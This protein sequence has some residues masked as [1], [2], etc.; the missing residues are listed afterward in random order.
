MDDLEHSVVIAERDWESFY[1]ESE[2]CSIQQAWLASLDDS[3]F[4]DTD[5]EKNSTQGSVLDLQTNPD[6]PNKEPEAAALTQ[7][8]TDDHNAENTSEEPECLSYKTDNERSIEQTAEISLYDVST[9]CACLTSDS[10]V[11]D[12]NFNDQQ[13]IASDIKDFREHNESCS[14]HKSCQAIGEPITSFPCIQDARHFGSS[15]EETVLKVSES[16]ATPKKEKERW[17]VTVNDSPVMLRVKSGQKKGRK[18]KTSR[19]LFQQI[20]VTERQC[21]ISNNKKEE[22]GEVT[23]NEQILQNE[24][25]QPVQTCSESIYFSPC[26]NHFCEEVILS[27]CNDHEVVLSPMK[28]PEKEA[29]EKHSIPKINCTS[30][31]SSFIAEEENIHCGFSFKCKDNSD[32]PTETLENNPHP[33]VNSPSLLVP[34][35]SAQLQTDGLVNDQSIANEPKSNTHVT[36]PDHPMTNNLSHIGYEDTQDNGSRFILEACSTTTPL[37][38]LEEQEQLTQMQEELKQP[39]QETQNQR[40]QKE[41]LEAAVG[42]NCPIYALSSFWDEMEKLTINDILHLKSAHNMSPMSGSV[43]AQESEAH[44]E[45]KG[46]LTSKH[47][48]VQESGL[49]DDFADSDYFTHVDESKLDRSSCELSTLSDYDEEFL[50]ILNRSGN[51]SPEPQY[52]KEQTENFKSAYIPGHEFDPNN[53]S[54]SLDIIKLSHQ[55]GIAHYLYPA[56]EVQSLLLTSSQDINL[57]PFELEV[58]RKTPVLS[59]GNTA[60]NESML[61]VS[62]ILTE[63]INGAGSSDRLSSTVVSFPFTQNLSVCEMYDDFFSDFEIGNFLFPSTQ[64]KTI[65]IFCASRSVVRDLVFPE[66]EELDFDPDFE[67]DNMPIRDTTCFSIQPEMSPS[68]SEMPNLC[69]SMI[70]RGNWSS[71]FSLRRIRFIGKGSTWNQKISSWIF[72]KEAKKATSHVSRAQQIAPLMQVGNKSLLQLAEPQKH[73]VLISKKEDFVFSINQADMCLV[74]IAF[75]SWVLKS[76]NS[77]S[78]DMWKTALL[79]NVSAISAIQYLRKYGKGHS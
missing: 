58:I 56:I 37:E 25:M 41:S 64:D 39:S 10:S 42:P 15:E 45:D 12:A 7:S 73:A 59:F 79:A 19:K 11:N 68:P 48:S 49:M 78:T 14:E 26:P 61:T 72:P 46:L 31:A 62:E 44:L 40:S 51:P 67:E 23:K 5:D 52:V 32:V 76:Y 9:A 13:H 2:E 70:Q 30:E 63:D 60:D 36:T 38:K 16:S 35:D 22:E 33:S 20:I 57:N 21:S 53:E 17:F 77:Q 3:G 28:E 18:K 75:A 1:E 6:K 24:F 55:D 27:S 4:S 47:D 54:E 74:C 69:F 65:P 50:Q 66:V 8:E 71:L 34:T 29:F 43:I